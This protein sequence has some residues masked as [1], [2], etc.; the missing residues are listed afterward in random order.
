MYAARTCNTSAL[1]EYVHG[2][3]I[4]C[5]CLQVHECLAT[6]YR[7]ERGEFNDMGLTFYLYRK[8]KSNYIP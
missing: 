3:G 4:M 5:E 7:W 2:N 6:S 1:K 8:N